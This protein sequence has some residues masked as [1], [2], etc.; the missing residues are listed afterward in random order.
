MLKCKFFFKK[1]S[2]LPCLVFVMLM[3][4]TL[5]TLMAS[6]RNQQRTLSMRPGNFSVADA[7]AGDADS[8]ILAAAAADQ[9]YAEYVAA[10]EQANI[11]AT[12]TNRTAANSI[13]LI[14][15]RIPRS[16]G[17][18]IVYLIKQLAR[19]NHFTHQRHQYRT[20]WNRC[21]SSIIFNLH[22][23]YFF[24]IPLYLFQFNCI[25]QNLFIYFLKLIIN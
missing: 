18:T 23:Q 21:Q 19:G 2:L 17:L 13:W 25:N 1:S 16:G 24:L 20:P 7:S 15:N 11:T 5:M 9:R 3:K 4:V 12:S 6:Q 22:L 8:A 14:F 10:L